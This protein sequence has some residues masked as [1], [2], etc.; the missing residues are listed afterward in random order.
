VEVP[1]IVAVKR[2]SLEDG[3]GIRSVVFFKGCPLRCVFCQNPETQDPRPEIAFY[4]E[5]CLRCGKCAAACPRVIAEESLSDGRPSGRCRACCKCVQA[6]P[7]GALVSIGRQYRVEDLVELLLCDEDY[8]RRS[9]GGVT[10][11]G[12]E[13]TMFPAYVVA[14]AVALKARGVHLAVETCGE[15]SASLFC[16]SLLPFF[17]LIYFDLKVADP[18]E[19]QA[20]TGRDNSR[21]FGSLALLAR[22]AADRLRVRIPVVPGVT[23][24][25]GNFAGLIRQLRTC[26]LH[27][28]ILLPYNP[29]G[30]Q[31]A[32]RLQR[33]QPR[34]MKR[35][36][37]RGCASVE[38]VA[39]AEA[40][41]RR[42][43]TKFM[44]AAEFADA[45][46]LFERI[47]RAICTADPSLPAGSE[48]R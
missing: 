7:G 2:H 27:G 20:C 30:L 29:L 6:C 24:S 3:P 26:G 8:Y 37:A 19:H 5:R 42:S 43:S 35:A 36:Q 48:A 34:V 1:Y 21:I 10:F 32:M 23:L 28:A 16:E 4:E 33:D 11:S 31:M 47:A 17:D 25:E 22:C 12:G 18:R 15:F 14:V 44:T 45:T 38:I 39:Q 13:C 9:G 40:P 41:T 46:T